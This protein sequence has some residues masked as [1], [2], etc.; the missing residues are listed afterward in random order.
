MMTMTTTTTFIG[1]LLCAGTTLS[2]TFV[3]SVNSYDNTMIRFSVTDKGNQE[4]GA[5]QRPHITQLAHGKAGIRS[6]SCRGHR[7][8]QLCGGEACARIR[9]LLPTRT[10]SSSFLGVPTRDWETEAQTLLVLGNCVSRCDISRCPFLYNLDFA[11]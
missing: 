5:K 7:A 3:I 11:S 9:A 8:L 10:M 2:S 6:Y 1:C 4:Q